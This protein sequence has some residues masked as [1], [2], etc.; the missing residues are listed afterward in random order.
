MRIPTLDGWR[1]LAIIMV[2]V[3]HY[4]SIFMGA[5]KWNL[6]QHGVT[7]FFVLSGYLITMNLLSMK[8][9]SL[10]Q[11]YLRRFFR[12]APA[13]GFYLL[14]LCLLTA[15]TG[16]KVMTGDSLLGCVFFF[17]NY[18]PET[19][20][21]TCTAHF[22]SLSVEEQFYLLWPFVLV[23]LGRKKSFVVAALATIAI[24]YFR[25][26][27]W[28]Y[29]TQEL[30]GMWTQVRADAIL[31]GCLLA[32]LLQKDSAKAW[33]SK[34]GKIVFCI[35]LP[36][37]LAETVWYTSLIPLHELILVAAMIGSTV[38]NPKAFFSKVLEIEHLKMT[39][40]LSYS[41]YLWQ[42]LFLRPNWG[43]F[44][45]F[46]LGGVMFFSWFCIEKPGIAL[47]KKIGSHLQS[48]RAHA[49]ELR[50]RTEPEFAEVLRAKSEI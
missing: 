11:F 32:A 42:Q 17:R 40:A 5:C 46:L 23:L 4:Q 45:F 41:L 35:A 14:F 48:R 3:A 10:S 25:F 2:L 18:I 9:I 50:G 29:F 30:R 15:L 37:F 22:W 49:Y 39:G 19:V 47:G 33:F 8:K 43:E 21:N 12:L 7:I 16:M 28:S 20:H 44:G 1:G 13:A 34:Y 31:V 6:G 36:L 27:H 26:T 24:A 38:L